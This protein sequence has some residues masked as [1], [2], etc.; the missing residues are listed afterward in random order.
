MKEPFLYNKH[1]S[2]KLI[3]I[4]LIILVST[5]ILSLVASLLTEPLFGVNF[6]NNPDLLGNLNDNNTV[7]AIKFVQ[8]VDSIA[9]FILPAIVFAFLASSRPSYYLQLRR[10]PTLVTL[11]A[12]SL[13]MIFGIPLINWLAQINSMLKLPSSMASLEHWMRQSEDTAT[14]VTEVFL[15]ATTTKGFIVNLFMMA[16]IPAIGEELFFRGLLM[17]LMMDWTKKKHLP[18]F[19]TAFLFSAM[20]M[21][22]YGFLPRFLMGVFFGYLLLWS[23]SLIVPMVTHFVNNA[24]A[25]IFAYLLNTGM[26]AEGVEK[27]GSG[28]DEYF[29]VIFSFVSVVVLIFTLYY[30]EKRY[31][32]QSSYNRKRLHQ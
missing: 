16:V 14:K 9:I 10:I 17:K 23:R 18:I 22:F 25:I 32:I 15:A 21:Q 7:R 11:L 28:P 6:L 13:V 24:M 2:L 27:L 20:H 8:I 29:S 30:Y 5:L 26:A 3:F 12:A 4:G 1:I 19:I 31:H